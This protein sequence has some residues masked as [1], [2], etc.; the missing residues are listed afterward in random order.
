VA[1]AKAG[2]LVDRHIVDGAVSA[3]SRLIRA[4]GNAARSAGT[5]RIQSYLVW[6]MAGFLAIIIWI[7]K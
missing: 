1:I 3:V 6:A 7:L 4:V 2:G 5:G